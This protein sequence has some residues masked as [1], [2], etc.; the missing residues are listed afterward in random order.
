MAAAWGELAH[1]RN[2]K[3]TFYYEASH[4]GQEQLWALR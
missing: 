4:Q 2:F 3:N 1:T